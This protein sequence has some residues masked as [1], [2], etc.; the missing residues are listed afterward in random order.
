MSRDLTDDEIQRRQDLHAELESIAEAEQALQNSAIMDYF[1]A[2]EVQAIDAL[3]DCDLL[4]DAMRLKLTVVA[5]TTRK[6]RQYLEEKR[7][8]RRLVERELEALTG[9]DDA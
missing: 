7:D 2:V 4:D 8:L 3:L 9:A 5:K 6:M 1:R